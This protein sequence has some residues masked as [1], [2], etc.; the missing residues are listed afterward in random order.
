M[1]KF[2]RKV[3]EVEAVQWRPGQS[4][5]AL[6]GKVTCFGKPPHVDHSTEI[7]PGDWIVNDGDGFSVVKADAFEKIFEPVAADAPESR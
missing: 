4:H 6:C 7:A 2:R 1:A 3:A 5:P